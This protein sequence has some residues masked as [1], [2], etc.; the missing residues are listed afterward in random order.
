MFIAIIMGDDDWNELDALEKSTVRLH[1]DELV[2]FTVVNEKTTH[3]LQNKVCATY[4]K[5]TA[6]NNVYLM[7]QLFELQLKEGGSIVSHLNEFNILFSQLL[8]QKLIFGEEIKAIF[9]PMFIAIIVG[10]IL[11]CYH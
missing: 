11:H 3:E 7:K 5:E 10:Y 8:A 1:L 2:Y 6:S 9:S 4:E